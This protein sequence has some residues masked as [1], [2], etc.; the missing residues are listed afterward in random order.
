MWKPLKPSRSI[1]SNCSGFMPP[2][3]HLTPVIYTDSSFSNN[4][5]IKMAAF[6]NIII[7]QV[8]KSESLDSKVTSGHILQLLMVINEYGALVEG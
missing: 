1:N 6:S 8:G 5:I 2:N 7:I 4:I 3:L